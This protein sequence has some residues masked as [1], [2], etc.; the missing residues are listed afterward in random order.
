MEKNEDVS[1]VEFVPEIFESALHD[2]MNPFE[3]WLLSGDLQDSDDSSPTTVIRMVKDILNQRLI[4]KPP[5]IVLAEAV[6]YSPPLASKIWNNSGDK[7]IENKNSVIL[8]KDLEEQLLQKVLYIINNTG[9]ITA[10]EI[11]YCAEKISGKLVCHNWHVDFILRHNDVIGAI[12]TDKIEE[13]RVKVSEESVFIYK[14]LLITETKGIPVELIACT[15]EVGYQQYCDARRRMIIARNANTS[16]PLHNPTDR[17]ER[18]ISIMSGA[19]MSGDCMLPFVILKKPVDLNKYLLAGTRHGIDAYIAEAVRTCMTGLLFCEFLPNC[20]VPFFDIQWKLIGADIRTPAAIL[21]DNCPSN[22]SEFSRQICALNNI[23]L[24]TLP[25]NST[26]Y[27]QM[28]DFG[29]FGAFKSKL[30]T[31]RRHNS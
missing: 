14:I 30:Q 25:P 26:Q 29:I 24:F 11:R 17:E 27:L 19:G 16:K 13:S 8:T 6:Q 31:F 21:L 23:K 12:Q 20:A 2:I 22:I 9:F 1:K 5:G 10:Q 15:D 3:L 7:K 28:F 4:D 18:H